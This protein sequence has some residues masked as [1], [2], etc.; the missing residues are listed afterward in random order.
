MRLS[1]WQRV[2]VVVSVLWFFVGGFIGNN[3]AVNDAGA[4]TTLQFEGCV[5]A[6]KRRLGEYGPCD[7]V[8]TPCWQQHSSWF[9]QNVEGHWWV[10]LAVALIP[11]PFGWL[12]GWMVISTGR[13]IRGGFS[14]QPSA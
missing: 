3:A 1:G 12:L 11:L 13:W 6:N 5:A 4:R 8:W 7:Q 14:K 2:G 10:A 9:M